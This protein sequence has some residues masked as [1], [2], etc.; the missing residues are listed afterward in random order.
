MDEARS[1]EEARAR[2]EDAMDL[3]QQAQNLF[4]KAT[5]RL[6]AISFGGPEW[7]ATWKLQDKI[8]SHWYLLERL[9]MGEKPRHRRIRLDPD[10]ERRIEEE[11]KK[12]AAETLGPDHVAPV[13]QLKPEDP[14]NG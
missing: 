5:E 4:G 12:K 10:T 13:H 14:S 8:R 3:V 1:R 7:E 9:F 11:E 6:A 2:V